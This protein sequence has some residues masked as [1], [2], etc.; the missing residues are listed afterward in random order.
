M[1][2]FVLIALAA[3]PNPYLVQAKLFQQSGDYKQCLKRIEQAQKWD[4][5]RE[6]QVDIAVYSGLCNYA[7]LKT[8]EAETEFK[9]ALSIDPAAKL[10][11]YTSPKVVGFFEALRPKATAKVEPAKVEPAK[12]EPAKVEPAKVEPAK[13]EPARVEPAKVEPAKVEPAKVEPAK[14]ESAK[15]QPEPRRRTPL[16]P[17][18]IGG[19]S[20]AA[21]AAGIAFGVQASSLHSRADAER[22]QVNA[23][24]LQQSATTFS[25]AANAGYAIAG[26]ALITAVI[27]FFMARAD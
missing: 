8:K 18:V 3:Q 17:F 24:S 5:S 4:S 12:V 1:T 19:V 6:E 11:P 14:V 27:V 20:L 10:P 15:T 22:V 9:L 25:I 7:L 13:V 21:L 23:F 16:L 2:L 26:A